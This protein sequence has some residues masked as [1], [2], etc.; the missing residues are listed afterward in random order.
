MGAGTGVGEGEF[1][2]RL[3]V[4]GG[5]R[6][7]EGLPSTRALA[8]WEARVDRS[9][10]VGFRTLKGGGPEWSLVGIGGPLPLVE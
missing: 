9:R 10:M 1:W 4:R 6:R 8:I 7:M 5:V 3:L 2:S